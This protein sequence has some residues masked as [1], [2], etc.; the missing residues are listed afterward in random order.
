MMTLPK[1]RLV[2]NGLGEYYVELLELDY[3]QIGGP[4]PTYKLFGT[5]HRSE[6]L[7]KEAF[8]KVVDTVRRKEAQ[9]QVEVLETYG[10]YIVTGG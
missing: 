5:I 10:E 2:R 1:V 9:T 4:I 8:E 6:L 3:R 7:A